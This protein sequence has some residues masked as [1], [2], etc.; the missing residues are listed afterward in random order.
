[1]AD[2]ITA[3]SG[4]ASGYRD[5]EELRAA[6]FAMRLSLGIGVLMLL[7]KTTAYLMTGSAA[8]LSDFA[9]SVVHV[10]AV[11]FAAF[12]LRLSTKPAA[13]NFLYGYE[14]ITFFSAG[15]EGAMI[16]VAAIWILVAAIEKWMAGL[17]LE[18]LGSGVVLLLAAGI[19][20]A[21]LGWYLLRVGKRSHSLI[22][23]ADGKHVLTDSLTSFGVVAGLGLVMLTGWKP[24]DPL[25]AIAVA[26]NILWSGGRLAWRSVVGLL[27]YSDPDAGKQIRCKL[28]S[29]C[30]EL[31]LQYHGVRF[32]TTGYRQIIEVHLLF[33]HATPVGEA[34]RLA[35]ALEERLPVELASPAEVVTHLES[36]E[37]HEAVHSQAHYVGRPE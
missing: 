3:A 23:E 4:P 1:M 7:G 12:S 18:H 28:D 9:E 21:G 22:L 20:N 8:I 30:S 14:R 27:D 34:H 6:R 32:R 5:P 16:I 2:S 37:D 26:A 11:A 13:P 15:F 25:I 31:G 10:V 17:K 36:L 33:P 29:L 19:L 24:F 35:T